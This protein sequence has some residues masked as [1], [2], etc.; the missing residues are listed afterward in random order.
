MKRVVVTGLGIV[1]SIGNN[2]V[3]VLQSLIEGRSGISF[4]QEYAEHGLRSQVAGSV[5][6]NVQELIDRKLMRFMANGHAYG[7]LAMQEAIQDA[8][9]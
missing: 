3:E 8:G 5:K 7:W 1:S 2:K 6:L 4:Q 9:L